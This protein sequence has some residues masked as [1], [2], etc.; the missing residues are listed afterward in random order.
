[1]PICLVIFANSLQLP[2]IAE[3]ARW[4]DA[5]RLMGRRATGGNTGEDEDP[6]HCAG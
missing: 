5:A 1:M 2:A 6:D 3:E 4:L